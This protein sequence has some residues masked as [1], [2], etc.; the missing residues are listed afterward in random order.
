MRLLIKTHS[1]WGAY[2]KKGANSNQYGSH[3]VLKHAEEQY[4]EVNPKMVCGFRIGKHYEDRED[5]P[6]CGRDSKGKEENSHLLSW[7]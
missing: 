6:G 3:I 4:R 1:K 5:D 7:T 2:W